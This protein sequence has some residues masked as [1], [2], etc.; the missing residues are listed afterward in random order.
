MSPTLSPPRWKIQLLAFSVLLGW[1]T[2]NPVAADDWIHWRG[3]EQNGV[4]LEKN[5]PDSFD[6]KAKA[7]GNIV[8]SQ[9]FGG[10]SAPLVMDGR[11][12]I[13]SGAG[14]GVNEGER[15]MCF[16]EKTGKPIWEYKVNVFHTTIV[17]SRLGWTTLAADPE[18]G[19]VYWHTTAGLMICLDGKTG[20]VIWEHSLTEE[21]GRISGY[22]GRIVSPIFDSGLVIVGVVN[23]SWGDQARG[24]NRFVA[25]DG[26]TGKV[27]WWGD[28]GT[29]IKG[30][31]YSNPV[32]AV[33]GGQ[34]LLIAGGADGGLHA[35]KV[36][37]G[38]L[39]WSL[40]FGTGVINSSPL[41]SGNLVYCS[42][43]EENPG[44]GP[45]GCVVCVDASQI[46]PATKMPKIVWDYR[47]GQRFGLASGALHDGKLYLP[48][49]TGDLFCFDAKNGKVLWRYRY[50]T[51]VRGA[52]LIADG[53]IYI[54]DVKGTIHIL[55]LN[56]NMAPDELEVFQYRFRDPK[57]VN[58]TNGTCIAVNG[59][60]Y[61]TTSTD[62]FCLGDPDA[63]AECG[64]YQGLPAETPF[65]ENAI[66]GARL[67][68]A[69]VVAKPGEKVELEVVL[70]DANGRTVKSNL[71]DPPAKWS[72]VT[73]PVPKGAT[74]GPPP[75]QATVEGNAAKGTVTLTPMPSQH[76]YVEADVAGQKAR[77][78]IR[79][80][81]NMPYTQDFEKIPDGAAPAGWVNAQAKFFVTTKDGK[82]VLS[83]VNTDS[84]PPFSRAD[85][86]IT[87]PAASYT[88]QCDLM[89]TLERGKVGDM[90][91]VNSRYTFIMDGKKDTDAAKREVRL[92]AWE[93]KPRINEAAEFD[94]QP[95]TWYTAKLSVEQKE[96][97]AIVRA[98]VWK[99][100]DKEPEKW[101]IEFEDPNPNR[102]GSAA[103]YGYVSN[104]TPT[105]P[106]SGIFYDN[107][108]VT[109]NK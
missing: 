27:V 70:V 50:G 82:K 103:V 19:Y 22:G 56:G 87:L 76:G 68:P 86:Y 48:S 14:E 61:F 77:A 69:D 89:G 49:D 17:S 91:I 10:R 78:R 45:I 46:D 59:H 43:G 9:P 104:I 23:A 93:A 15:L 107:V 8:W 80:A 4:S 73:P 35:F 55:P 92:V 108:I 34:R 62:L 51:E 36:R 58:E 12:Y 37:T 74:A 21:F 65:K 28:T 39:M 88:I 90:G 33:I 32:I 102:E 99:T 94:W 1:S 24:S 67:Y 47:K 85:A 71:P 106:G 11:I 100:G 97:T 16:D 96:K 72:V 40:P 31:Y 57:G 42:H 101:N 66:A 44:G 13:I 52:P 30:T 25:L 26:K 53:K 54:F 75:L 3:P 83:K 95:G 5:L 109:P 20:K 6:I 18:T 7:K 79:V 105:E 64:K 41:V 98:K 38:E 60:V 2:A 29:P 84:R 81:P 63:K